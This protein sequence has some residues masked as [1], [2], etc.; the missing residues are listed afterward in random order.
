MTKDAALYEFF[1][2]AISGVTAYPETSVP[3]KANGDSEDAALPYLTYTN[4]DAGFGE[5]VSLTVNLWFPPNV[6]EAVPNAAARA[7]YEK[8]GDGGAIVHYDGGAFWLKR[9]TPFSQPVPLDSSN[10][11]RRYI[12]ITEEK[13]SP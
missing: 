5:E 3:S 10:I 13:L 9:G 1:N 7:L 4:P 11:K 2:N 12:N 6:G 8:L